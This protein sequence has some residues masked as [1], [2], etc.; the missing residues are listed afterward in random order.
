MDALAALSLASALMRFAE[1][2][3]K[4]LSQAPKLY[5]PAHGAL[6]DRIDVEAL[7]RDLLSLKQNLQR[8]APTRCAAAKHTTDADKAKAL[9]ALCAR[10]LG[11]AQDL[12]AHL[13]R[14]KTKPKATKQGL[15]QKK[16]QPDKW[17]S[18]LGADVLEAL[19]SQQQPVMM[20]FR[21]W[22]DFHTALRAVWNRQ[23]MEALE[24]SI[25]ETRKDIQ[26]QMLASIRG[27][28]GQ[29]ARQRSQTSH[30]LKKFAT[31]VMDSFYKSE[32]TFISQMQL[33]S[34][35]LLQFAESDKDREDDDAFGIS[36][37][38][39][40]QGVGSLQ[41]PEHAKN[42]NEP[43]VINSRV[44]NEL[45]TLISETCVL[46]SLSF[47]TMVDRRES[48]EKAHARTF[49][50]IYKD[51]EN[52]QVPWSNFVDWL[53]HGDGIYWINGK[54]GCGKSTFMRYLYEN[55]TTQQE[56][57]T[58]AAGLPCEV[59]SFFFWNSGGE[60]Q[61][62]QLGLLRSLLFDILQRHRSLMRE[63]MPDVW[64]AWSARADA[65]LEERLPYDSS[66][67]PS[68]PE[69]LSV[70]ALRGIFQNAL[71]CLGKSTKLCFF[72]DGLDEYGADHSDI[73][74]LTTQCAVLRNVKFCLSSRPLEVFETS[75]AGLPTLRLQDLTHG[76]LSHYVPVPSAAHA[77][78]LTTS[79]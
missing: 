41:T 33:Q 77:T 24:D 45:R 52:A 75:F 34:Q 60:H 20:Q 21:A 2:G 17:R 29:L 36:V 8:R 61:K 18:L 4:L 46:S 23:E 79:G 22:V 48:V 55:K 64:G 9:E 10:C 78:A 73:I 39:N 7:V 19:D 69:A 56:L 57:A 30:E 44:E 38:D 40:S 49:G 28:F 63:A 42:Y 65:A 71:E 76:D 27:A 74:R 6:T 54:V 51:A 68:E 53:R 37:G 59:Y 66:S 47:A 72:I 14:L 62:S 35:R 26:F 13:S 1:Y 32:D 50:W 11:A 58:W 12:L 5:K 67:L 70:E 16:S 3:S 15:S 43:R 25:W 31:R